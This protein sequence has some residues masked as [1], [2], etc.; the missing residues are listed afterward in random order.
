MKRDDDSICFSAKLNWKTE[1]SNSILLEKQIESSSFT[2]LNHKRVYYS[3]MY[4]WRERRK[5]KLGRRDYSRLSVF[6]SFF[7]FSMAFGSQPLCGNLY[8]FTYIVRRCLLWRYQY[9]ICSWLHKVMHP[10]LWLIASSSSQSAVFLQCASVEACPGNNQ[11][12]VGYSGRACG[13]CSPHYYHL[14]DACK[15]AKKFVFWFLSACPSN[16]PLYVLLVLICIILMA[17]ILLRLGASTYRGATFS[18]VIN[19]IQISALFASFKLQW[20]SEIQSV[21]NVLTSF[22]F[23]IDLT[24]P[25]CTSTWARDHDLM[26][27]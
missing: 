27:S 13:S 22:N 24:S 6:S 16:A 18:S 7:E 23:N 2:I 11:C 12:G 10:I 26:V 5:Q 17:F 3:R 14:N 20:P 8:A 19:M 9:H 15:S 4:I 25:E 1:F 21:F